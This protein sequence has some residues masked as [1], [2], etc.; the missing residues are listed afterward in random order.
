[1][2]PSKR[3]TL[4]LAAVSAIAA[5]LFFQAD[6]FWGLVISSLIVVWALIGMLPIM[7][8]AWRTKVGFVAAV[9]LGSL[10]VLWPTFEG[11]S[12][13]KIKCPTL[14]EG[15]H[16]VRRREGPRPPGRPPARLHGRGRGGDPRQARQVRR[17]DAPRAGR[18][19]HFHQGEGL[20]KREELKKLE[21]KVHVSAPESGGREDQVQGPGRHEAGRRSLQE[22]V[23]RRALADRRRHRRGRLQ[24]PPGGRD[25]DPRQGGRA[26]E[27]DGQP[28]RRRARS[29]GDERHDARRGHHHRG[30]RQGQGGSSSESRRSSAR[31]RASSSRCSTTTPTSSAR[32]PT[33]RSPSP[34][35]SRSASRTRRRPRQDGEEQLRPHREASGRD[36]EPG[37]RAPEEV[38]R[39]AQRPGRPHH[40]LRED[41]RPRRGDRQV[42]REGLAHVL[43]L[44]SRRGH[45]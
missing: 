29:Q 38:D 20:L 33:R 30:P 27:G 13:G 9:F 16:H 2:T 36:D 25:A 3:N 35:A 34:R 11:M 23:R 45:R 5:Y 14:R 40:R 22:E 15:P 43:P 12:D 8:G 28:P 32:S 7:D 19:V 17:R 26:G 44:Q 6:N 24:D 18:R 4:I 39:D 42:H 31:R 1:M 37:A 41:R 21:E 10:V